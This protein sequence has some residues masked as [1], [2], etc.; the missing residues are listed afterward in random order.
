[1]L[2]STSVSLAIN[3]TELQTTENLNSIKSILES[4]ANLSTLSA[5]NVTTFVSF[6]TVIYSLIV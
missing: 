1:M 3:D 2:V 5:V 6:N 4:V